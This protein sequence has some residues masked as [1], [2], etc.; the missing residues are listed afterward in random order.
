VGVSLAAAQKLARPSDPHVRANVDTHLGQAELPRTV[1]GLPPLPETTPPA[2]AEPETSQDQTE[3][4]EA[5]A[6]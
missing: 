4:P 3:P 5:A 6:G 1:E 2:A